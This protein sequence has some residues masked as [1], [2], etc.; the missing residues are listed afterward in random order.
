MDG[1]LNNWTV[2]TNEEMIVVKG[3]IGE[4]EDVRKKG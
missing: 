3:G 1:K 2:L 4:T